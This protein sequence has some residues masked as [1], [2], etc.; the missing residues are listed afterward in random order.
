MAPI[1][2]ISFS[3]YSG[4]SFFNHHEIIQKGGINQR[5]ALQ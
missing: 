3:G 5:E 2:A 1:G 4:S